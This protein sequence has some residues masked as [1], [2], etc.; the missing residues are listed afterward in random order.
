[1]NYCQAARIGNGWRFA[2]LPR[3]PEAAPPRS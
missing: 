1:M 2:P 3:E